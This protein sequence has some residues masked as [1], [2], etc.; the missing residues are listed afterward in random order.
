ML[1]FAE[2]IGSYFQGVDCLI[3]EAS[4]PGQGSH[5][6]GEREKKGTNR[7]SEENTRQSVKSSWAA[8]S[9]R[10]RKVSLGSTEY[11]ESLELQ[12][13]ILTATHWNASIETLVHCRYTFVSIS[14]LLPTAKVGAA[15]LSFLPGTRFLFLSSSLRFHRS[16][17]GPASSFAAA[18]TTFFPSSLAAAAAPPSPSPPLF[19]LSRR[20]YSSKKKKA[21]KAKMPPKKAVVQEKVLLGRPGNNLK[22]GIVCEH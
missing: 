10:E 14:H 4:I 8:E 5:V 19:F 12:P 20:C 18:T 13:V 11:K 7:F 9:S 2:D 15:I 1:V 22:S 16:A 6:G 3:S 17:A 21:S